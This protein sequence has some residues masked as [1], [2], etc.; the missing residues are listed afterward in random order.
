VCGV[1]TPTT[2]AARGKNCGT[3]DIGCGMTQ[4]CGS[5]SGA[6]QN[7]VCCQPTTCAAQGWSC[8]D[9]ELGCGIIQHCGDCGGGEVCT[10]AGTCC[11]P[12]TCSAAGCSYSGPDG[13][14][15]TLSCPPCNPR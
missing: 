2:C 9:Q 8:G 6:C 12:A 7:N 5:C 13:C 4:D 14:G 1:C 3:F 10:G 11:Q 15:G